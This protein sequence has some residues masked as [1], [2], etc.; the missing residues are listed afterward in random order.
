MERTVICT[1]QNRQPQWQ[2]LFV[3]RNIPIVALLDHP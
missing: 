2:E 3:E 1:I